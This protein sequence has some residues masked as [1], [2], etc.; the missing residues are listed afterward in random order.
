MGIGYFYLLPLW[1]LAYA[2]PLW[3]VNY[4]LLWYCFVTD[5]GV[6][7]MVHTKNGFKIIIML[8]FIVGVGVDIYYYFGCFLRHNPEDYEIILEVR[9]GEN[10]N[11]IFV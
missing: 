7:E 4:N 2:F 10:K 1:F 5:H 11:T 8:I 6:Y 9:D 3:D